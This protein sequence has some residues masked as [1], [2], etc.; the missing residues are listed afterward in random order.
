[1]SLTGIVEHDTIKLPR[2]I[3]LP[4]GTHVQ[5]VTI[6]GAQPT[7]RTNGSLRHLA[8]N[9]VDDPLTDGARRHDDYVVS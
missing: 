8:E 7:P 1:M 4:D 5:I 9:P 3:H 2:G 6:D